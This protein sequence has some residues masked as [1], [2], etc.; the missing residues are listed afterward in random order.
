MEEFITSEA[1]AKD[2]RRN[3]NLGHTM[4]LRYKGFGGK[5]GSPYRVHFR[6]E[7]KKQN[8]VE[9]QLGHET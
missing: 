2:E 3:E 9:L 6:G 1:H 8:H 7:W 4:P 5:S